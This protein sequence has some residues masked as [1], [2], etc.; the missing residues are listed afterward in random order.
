MLLSCFIWWKAIRSG[1]KVI[2]K[3]Q[4]TDEAKATDVT[5]VVLASS[6]AFMQSQYNI[7]WHGEVHATQLK[8]HIS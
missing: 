2:S 5:T 8:I 6:W 4:P 7:S 3:E 1:T